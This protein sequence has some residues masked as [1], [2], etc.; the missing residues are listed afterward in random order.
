MVLSASKAA[1]R[2]LVRSVRCGSNL[3]N[4]GH[5]LPDMTKWKPQTPKSFVYDGYATAR[6]PFSV[7]N[8]Y[9]F[10]VKFV[11][12]LA[13]GFWLPFFVVEYQLRK[14]NQ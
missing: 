3:P 9:S 13:A 14:A 1:F 11:G 10:F 6:L 8:K 4:H 7:A 5:T 12:I 2:P